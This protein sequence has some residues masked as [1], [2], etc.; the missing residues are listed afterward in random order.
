MP[1]LNIKPYDV[2]FYK[3]CRYNPILSALQ[4]YRINVEPF[5]ANDIFLYKYEQGDC[6]PRSECVMVEHEDRIFDE[7]GIQFEPCDLLS[8]SFIE[9]SIEEGIPVLISIDKFYWSDL[10]WNMPWYNKKHMR[11]FFLITGIDTITEM[12]DII[13][14]FDNG[15]DFYCFCNTMEYGLL[16]RCYQGVEEVYGKE[17]QELSRIIHNGD[18]VYEPDYY[19]VFCRNMNAYK[20]K[21]GKSLEEIMNCKRFYQENETDHFQ[22]L[23]TVKKSLGTSFNCAHKRVQVYE[24]SF[25]WG[26]DEI[27]SNAIKNSYDAN[28]LLICLLRKAAI[29]EKADYETVKK[30][31]CQLDNIYDNEAAL[32]TRICDKLSRG[33]EKCFN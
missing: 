20:E 14:V 10:K 32:Y 3:A 6:I 9:S 18:A 31:K 23:E 1:R 4:Y 25:F 17:K 15:K 2:F 29:A 30:I 16:E 24:Y 28:Y 33:G 27:I 12:V 11:H 21:I 8:I 7:L 19:S 22:I 26:E 5:F 13:D